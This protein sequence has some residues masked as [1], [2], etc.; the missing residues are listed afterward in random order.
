[1]AGVD[2]RLDSKLEEPDENTF[3]TAGWF[4]LSQKAHMLQV[5]S[6]AGRYNN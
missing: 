4:R 2:K 5:L 1:V 3:L 6:P